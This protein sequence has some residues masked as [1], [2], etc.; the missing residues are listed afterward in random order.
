M[1]TSWNSWDSCILPENTQDG[2][3]FI[4]QM[5]TRLVKVTEKFLCFHGTLTVFISLHLHSCVTSS[6]WRL[7]LVTRSSWTDRQSDSTSLWSLGGRT[8]A[9]TLLVS[10]ARLLLWPLL[11]KCQSWSHQSLC[12]SRSGTGFL[13]LRNI[14]VLIVACCAQ[15]AWL[16]P[17]DCLPC[18]PNPPKT[19]HLVWGPQSN[20]HHP[21][22]Y[23]VLGLK[24]FPV[25]YKNIHVF[26]LCRIPRLKRSWGL[27]RDESPSVPAQ[28][29][30][31]MTPA[32]QPLSIGY[33]CVPSN[34]LTM[35]PFPPMT[36]QMEHAMVY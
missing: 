24:L 30:S 35:A 5:D 3:T 36:L 10:T 7:D 15:P 22:I 29:R 12:F 16:H 32:Q 14:K 8:S 26:V 23:H 20:D 21:C 13:L 2:T 1:P 27:F 25:N 4:D 33:T 17:H 34:S 31:V 28:C 6:S 11:H 9:R 18:S 19:L